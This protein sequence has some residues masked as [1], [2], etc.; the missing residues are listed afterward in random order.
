MSPSGPVIN[1]HIITHILA[2]TS[3][4]NVKSVGLKIPF[5]FPP[6]PLPPPM[7]VAVVVAVVAIVE[8]LWMKKVIMSALPM[9]SVQ[10][11]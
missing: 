6:N 4:R 11:D 10:L 5:M 3:L 7:G 9:K 1:A 2:P 8:V